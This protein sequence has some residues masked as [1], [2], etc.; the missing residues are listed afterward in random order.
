MGDTPTKLHLA[1]LLVTEE[2]CLCG[3]CSEVLLL[4]PVKRNERSYSRTLG[5]LD[6]EDQLYT[7]DCK[8]SYGTD[9]V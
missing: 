6:P 8:S 3:E 4:L 9:Y 5:L 7:K 1:F 2:G